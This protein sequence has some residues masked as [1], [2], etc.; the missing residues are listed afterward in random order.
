MDI[1]TKFNIGDRVWCKSGNHIHQLT[2]GHLRVEITDSKGTF[3]GRVFDNFTPQKRREEKYMM[4]ET[5]IGSG[6]LYS[7]TELYHTE[8]EAKL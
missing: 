4:E 5:G 3:E 6:P 2:I 8:D 7:D 1:K